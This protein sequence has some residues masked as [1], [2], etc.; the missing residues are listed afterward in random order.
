MS[1]VPNTTIEFWL[2]NGQI[3]RAD[4]AVY[5]RCMA[6]EQLRAPFLH[7]RA[8]IFL[9]SLGQKH[10]DELIPSFPNLATSFFKGYELAKFFQAPLAK[11]SREGRRDPPGFRQRRKWRLWASTLL[12]FC[13]QRGKSASQCIVAADCFTRVVR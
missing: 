12:E 8:M 11:H 4:R 6:A 1:A 3:D 10:R 9:L 5:Q 13:P 2:R 7:L